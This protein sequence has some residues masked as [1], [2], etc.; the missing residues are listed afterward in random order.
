[1]FTPAKRSL[2][3]LC[4]LV[5]SILLVNSVSVRATDRQVLPGHVPPAHARLRLVDRLASTNRLNLTIG[6]PLRN[7]AAL[8]NL[9]QQIYDPAS[10]QYHRYLTL[11]QFTKRFGPTE[12]DYQAAIAF[13]Q[14]NGFVVTGTHLN[15]TLLDAHAAVADI[16]RTFR[17]RMTNYSHPKEARTFYAPDV[18]PT[19]DANVPLFHVSGLD[20]YTTPRPKDLR[21]IAMSK[22]TSATAYKGTGPGGAYYGK[23]FRAAYVPGTS[24]TGTGQAVGLFELNGY[25]PTD[26][27]TY[28]TK[29]G[30]PKVP[31]RNVLID[32][33]SGSAG[34]RRTGTLNEEVALDIEMAISMA[35]GLSQVIV[36]EG[37]PSATMAQ[38]NDVLNRM[39]TD[40]MARQL[41]CSWGFD[42]DVITQQIFQQY[43]AQGQS[44]FMASGDSGAFTGSVFQPSDDPYITMVGGTELTTDNAHAWVSETTWNGSGGGISTVYPIPD[45]QQ[46][47]DMSANQGSSTMRNL[48]DV[49]MIANG[50]LAIADNGQSITL[51]GTSIAAPLWAGFAALVNEQASASGKPAVGFINPTIYA[52][53]KGAG[54]A[55]S[56]HDITTGDNTTQTS[57]GFFHAVR[58][59]D[60]CTGWGTPNGTNFINA[61]LG[62]PS[63]GLLITSPLGFT[64]SGPVGGPFNVTSQSY[65]LTN[66]GPITLHWTVAN[67]AP[68]LTVAPTS[69]TLAPGGPG[70]TVSVSLNPS[71]SA[72]L[73]GTYTASVSFIDL[74]DAVNQD[75][76]FSLSVGNSGFETDDFA[77]WTVAANLSSSFADS[78]DATQELGAST[79]PNVDDSLF[80]HAGIYGAFL[81]QAKSL[82]LLSQT[83][84]TVPGQRYVVSF[85]VDNPADGTPNEFR[86]SWNGTVLFDQANMSQ[87]AWTNMSYIVTATGTKSV[88][89]FGFRND[90]NAF[91]LD[92]VSVQPVAPPEFVKVV[93]TNQSISFTWSGLDSL[94]YQVQYTSMPGSA[95]W[96]DLGSSVSPVNGTATLSDALTLSPQRFYRVV[97]VP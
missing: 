66:A 41:S 54:Y 6:L 3:G 48:P 9:L 29:T 47:I 45:W 68:W 25:Y 13:A 37:S 14:A 16:E 17:V 39:A 10:A 88:L 84:P 2:P 89:Q 60:L 26:I 97:V 87:F 79:I 34:G 70:T 72:L 23:D 83:L 5:F 61:V 21:E 69:G 1:M 33:F 18:E 49:A 22:S 63:G 93:Q 82:G 38:I 85:W 74:D 96:S 77:Y 90:Q 95:D 44:F 24:L 76:Q 56:F 94:R 53:G 51:A 15:R 78:V 57:P 58:G 27:T 86:A 75:R 50:V 8:T 46:G 32:G 65:S 80:V 35:P 59:Y 30:L 62:L 12:E 7:R 11:D 40:N 4:R 20:N 64:A 67:N 92:D 71:A 42:I 81:G 19:I 55:S 31:V 36:Y 43:A 52:I 28:E 91:G 73:L